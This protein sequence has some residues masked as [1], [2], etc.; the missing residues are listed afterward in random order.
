MIGVA[1]FQ[2]AECGLPNDSRS[3]DVII[4][5]SALYGVAV[6]FVILRVLSKLIT[7]TFCFEDHMIICAVLLLAVPFV[8]ALSSKPIFVLVHIE[9]K[10][11]FADLAKWPSKAS[12]T[13][14]GTSRTVH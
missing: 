12:V 6:I 10:G 13:T 2:A 1:R 14:Y 9:I 11:S 3:T 8:C 5:M 4:V 7:Q